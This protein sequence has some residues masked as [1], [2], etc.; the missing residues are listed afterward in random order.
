MP[1]K[2]D[3][4]PEGSL[5]SWEGENIVLSAIFSD[6][7]YLYVRAYSLS[8]K[9]EK[10]IIRKDGVSRACNPVDCGLP[11]FSVRDGAVSRQEYWS[12]LANTG[13]QSL[14]EHISCCPGHQL[15]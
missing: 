5:L 2:G 14:L 13:C 6:D 15:P 1:H 8:D 12:A 7:K 11:G 10:L 4:A 3:L 9:P